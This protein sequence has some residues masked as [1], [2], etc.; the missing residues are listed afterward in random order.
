MVP[1]GQNRWREQLVLEEQRVM[2]VVKWQGSQ[3]VYVESGDDLG[4][5]VKG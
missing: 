1:R 2:G 3:R 4:I 5:E